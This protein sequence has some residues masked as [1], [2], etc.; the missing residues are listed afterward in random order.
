M[1]NW[2]KIY[3]CLVIPLY[4]LKNLVFIGK[5]Q[6]GG[7]YEDRGS[8][9]SPNRCNQAAKMRLWPRFR[10]HGVARWPHLVGDIPSFADSLLSP[11]SFPISTLEF[12]ETTF[13]LL[14]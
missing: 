5:T 1:K 13:D 4:A 14:F 8:K 6:W 7:A 12:D 11:A 2:P 9:R 3:L 10:G